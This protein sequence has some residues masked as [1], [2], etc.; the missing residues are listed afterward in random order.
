MA[1][2]T[3]SSNSAEA[4]R[5]E[6]ERRRQQDSEARPRASHFRAGGDGD[7]KKKKTQVGTGGGGMFADAE[8]MK[9]KLRENMMKQE[10]DVAN[11]YHDYGLFQFVA[12]HPVFERTTLFIITLNAVYISLDTDLNK[13]LT[14]MT[15]AWPF[16]LSEHGFCFYFTLEWFVRFMAFEKKRN[17]LRDAWFVFDS[18][19]VAMMFGETWV[20]NMVMILMGGTEANQ[21]GGTGLMRLLRLLRLSR[22]ARMVKLLR[23]MPELLILIK[24]MVSAMRSVFFTLL[25]QAIILYV[26][27]ITFRQLTDGLEVGQDKFPTVI[28]SMHTLLVY[29]TLMDNIGELVQQ[30]QDADWSFIIVFYMFVLISALTVMNMLIGVLC[31][32]VSAVAAIEKEQLTVIYVKGQVQELL[33]QGGVDQDG[34][35]MISKVEF[36]QILENPAAARLLAEVGVDVFGLVELADFIFEADE[37]GCEAQLTFGDFMDVVLSLRGSNVASV[38]DIVDLRKLLSATSKQMDNKFQGLERRILEAVRNSFGDLERGT[39]G[40]MAKAASMASEVQKPAKK[41][42]VQEQRPST[43]SWKEAPASKGEHMVVSEPIE[44]IPPMPLETDVDWIG[45]DSR[46]LPVGAP[47]NLPMANQGTELEDAG[48]TLV[49]NRVQLELDRLRQHV[50][51]ELAVIARD[52]ERKAQGLMLLSRN[53]QGQDSMICAPDGNGIEKELAGD[54][55]KIVQSSA[56]VSMSPGA[57]MG[58]SL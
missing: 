46:W 32:V 9:E 47:P 55:S 2:A 13:S 34:D 4:E 22:L 48:L 42:E 57:E 28:Q 23:A 53:G 27:G 30:L 41:S 15:A 16:Q 33:R 12:R 3:H 50:D 52:I 21:A 35:G 44:E 31:E 38:K 18:C 36:A 25:L 58:T 37:Q 14:L 10:Y 24:G 5:E 43:A 7:D 39:N 51:E 11:F 45:I 26:F 49:L 20:M 8:K 40:H 29:G 17:G 19:L 1:A 56:V 54:C 6:E